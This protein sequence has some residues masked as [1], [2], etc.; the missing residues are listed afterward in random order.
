[1][2]EE[3]LNEGADSSEEK[4]SD[5]IADKTEISDKGNGSTTIMTVGEDRPGHNLVEA[6]TKVVSSAS[7][8]RPVADNSL[9]KIV[10]E[11]PKKWQK[12]K[13]YKDGDI[14]EVSRES[15]NTFIEIG[16]AKLIDKSE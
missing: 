6:T 1:M 9:V 2:L 11:Y 14:R 16:I 12:E 15:A 13:F 8:G 7:S 4:A 5:V 10:I 3:E